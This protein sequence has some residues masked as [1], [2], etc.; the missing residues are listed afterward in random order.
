MRPAQVAAHVLA[1]EGG[2]KSIPF[3]KRSWLSAN[4][5]VLVQPENAHRVMPRRVFIG[6]KPYF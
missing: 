2:Q 4:D 5:P 3:A 1:S 6:I